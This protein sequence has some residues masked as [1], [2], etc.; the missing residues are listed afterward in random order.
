MIF[1]D[2]M[3]ILD[4]FDLRELIYLGSKANEDTVLPI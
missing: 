1:P 4:K 2:F 3:E